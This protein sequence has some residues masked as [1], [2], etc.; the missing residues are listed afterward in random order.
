MRNSPITVL[1][2]AALICS[3]SARADDV[4]RA[5]PQILNLTHEIMSGAGKIK[6]RQVALGTVLKNVVTEVQGKPENVYIQFEHECE[7]LHGRARDLDTNKLLDKVGLQKTHLEKEIAFLEAF[8]KA[9]ATSSRV[10]RALHH[11]GA[12]AE[13]RDTFR[14]QIRPDF[15]SLRRLLPQLNAYRGYRDQRRAGRHDY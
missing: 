8:D 13:A 2:A 9:Y 1:I 12:N 6:N 10:G 11:H 14:E 4:A 7:S 15:S 3:G 5:Q